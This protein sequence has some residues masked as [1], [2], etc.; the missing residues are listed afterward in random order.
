MK[1]II[2]TLLAL[3]SNIAF[4]DQVII[5][6]QNINAGASAQFNYSFV[7]GNAS[8]HQIICYSSTTIDPNSIINWPWGNAVQT[9]NL[10]ILLKNNSQFEGSFANNSG[11]I[12][13]TNTT[14][15]QLLYT[16]GYTF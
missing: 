13:L 15:Q 4:A 10:P 3:I 1:S 8:H 5:F 14:T 16:C 12:K 11:A 2:L 6:E 7:S 9:G